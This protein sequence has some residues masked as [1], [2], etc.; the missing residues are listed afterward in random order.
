MRE[1]GKEGKRWRNKW[2]LFA[3]P[4]HQ[5]RSFGERDDND[6]VRRATPLFIHYCFC[7]GVSKKSPPVRNESSVSRRDRYL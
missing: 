6:D 2:P 7:C 5:N 1:R 4:R 3:L